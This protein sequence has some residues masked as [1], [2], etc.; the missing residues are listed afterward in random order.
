LALPNISVNYNQP[1]ALKG[2]SELFGWPKKSLESNN[3]CFEIMG[4]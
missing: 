3:N 1:I 2:T 4:L